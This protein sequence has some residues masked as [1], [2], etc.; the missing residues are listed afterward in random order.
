[1]S[2]NLYELYT[3]CM[4]TKVYFRIYGEMYVVD[5]NLTMYFKADDH[6]THVYY[7][8]GT[9][10]MI[11]FGL[12]KVEIEISSNIEYGQYF[13]RSGRTYIINIKQIFHINT[14]KQIVVISDNLGAAHTIR[15]PKNALRT[16]MDSLN[17]PK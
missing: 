10:F 5:L 13:I 9:H 16:L 12:S 14:I 7:S 17:C 15:L 8:S 11:P 6:Y 1:M 3:S 4:Q 2:I